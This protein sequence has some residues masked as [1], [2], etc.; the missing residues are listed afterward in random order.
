MTSKELSEWI[1]NEFKPRP[2]PFCG[3]PNPALR[4]MDGMNGWRTGYA[5]LCD[6]DDDGCGAEGGW[7][8][9]PGEALACWNERRRVWHCDGV[10]VN[11]EEH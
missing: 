3:R 6:Y 5:V 2:C 10:R 4:I 1:D 11:T 8:K 7:R 9:S